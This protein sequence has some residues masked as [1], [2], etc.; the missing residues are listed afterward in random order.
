MESF[1]QNCVVI[2]FVAILRDEINSVEL[3]MFVSRSRMMICV[4]TTSFRE[5]LSPS[6]ATWHIFTILLFRS[7]ASYTVELYPASSSKWW[8]VNMQ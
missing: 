4:F 5:I 2:R 6:K 8:E 1:H 7:I 3:R